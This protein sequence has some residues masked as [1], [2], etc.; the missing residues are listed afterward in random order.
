MQDATDRGTTVIALDF[1]TTAI[2]AVALRG[3]ALT[4]SATAG[5]EDAVGAA[6]EA[7][8]ELLSRAG[9]TA[10]EPRWIAATGTRL[11]SV[12][13]K[14]LGLP[15]R[16]VDEFQAIGRGGLQL[17]GLPRALVVSM[18]TGTAFVA[19]E[20]GLARHLG[21]TALGGGTLQGL[22][23]RILGTG[24]VGA[25][26]AMAASGSLGRVDLTVADIAAGAISDLAPDLTAANFGKLDPGA[27]EADLALGLVNLVVQNIAL[28][29]SFVA[30]GVALHDIV[31]VGRLALLPQ[32]A[33]M[34]GRVGDLT[35][36]DF[37]IPEGGDY[38]TAIGAALS[39]SDEWSPG[40]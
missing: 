20:R 35:G 34:V 38:A 6:R 19:A 11:G 8:E 23:Q 5:G 14:R 3:G 17:S 16:K 12:E 37:V 30:R 36:N 9:L 32:T 18:G 15:L 40:R 10:D 4:G 2:K 33:G 29:A 13:E 26:A 21:G 1:G 22:G 39:A 25:I 27:A 24:E 31:L 7:L 28:M